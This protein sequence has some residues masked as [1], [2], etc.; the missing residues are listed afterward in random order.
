MAIPSFALASNLNSDGPQK[1][2]TQDNGKV[3]LTVTL[4]TPPDAGGKVAGALVAGLAVGLG[5]FVLVGLGAA[6]RVG[7]ALGG[8]VGFA[9][10]VWVGSTDVAVAVDVGVGGIAVAVGVE[11]GGMGVGDTAVSIG[12]GAAAGP[13]QPISN[14][15]NTKTM[16]RH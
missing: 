15:L 14:T 1:A 13:A 4:V 11:L 7:V 6:V 12:V 2:I 16:M 8:S 3:F 5:A 9:V 10:G